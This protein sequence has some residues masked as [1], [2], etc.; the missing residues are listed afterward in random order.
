MPVRVHGRGEHERDLCQQ[1]ADVLALEVVAVAEARAQLLAECE[2]QRR[3]DPLVGVV[4]G[5]VKHELR[6]AAERQIPQRPAE[7]AAAKL[8]DG[9]HGIARGQ[10]AHGISDERR[11]IGN[12][13]RRDGKRQRDRQRPAERQPL[14]VEIGIG[15]RDGVHAR[16][17]LPREG[18]KRVARADG[19][20]DEAG[21]VRQQCAVRPRAHDAVR[22]EGV[23]RLK[24]AHGCRRLRAEDAVERARRLPR[25]RQP[26]LQQ[27]HERAP[28][29]LF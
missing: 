4:R 19:A 7:H 20:R 1:V 17:V 18:G 14:R 8:S 28:V 15:E 23:G 22:R 24:C 27:R 12:V 26:Q 5:V 9:E 2:Q 16:A 3:R 21:I 6:P 25:A 29:A 10:P 13:R 11:G